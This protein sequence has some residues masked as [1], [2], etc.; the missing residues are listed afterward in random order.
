[1]KRTTEPRYQD[2]I[3]AE[4]QQQLAQAQELEPTNPELA[5]TL[6]RKA[7]ERIKEDTLRLISGRGQL[8]YL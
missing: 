4:Y 1:M 7:W 6:R 5:A 2:P 3:A 8:G